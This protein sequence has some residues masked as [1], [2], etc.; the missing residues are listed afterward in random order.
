MQSQTTTTGETMSKST[1]NVHRKIKQLYG[2]LHKAISSNEREEIMRRVIHFPPEY[3]TVF[4]NLIGLVN[5]AF[6]TDENCYKQVK[7]ILLSFQQEVMDDSG[8]LIHFKIKIKSPIKSPSKSPG[9]LKSP[10]KSPGKTK[11]PSKS[12][13]KLMPLCLLPTP[14]THSSQNSVSNLS[15]LKLG[16]FCTAF[17]T[18]SN[19]YER[20]QFIKKYMYASKSNGE[21]FHEFI[22]DISVDMVHLSTTDIDEE[23]SDPQMETQMRNRLI[24]HLRYTNT[25]AAE[26]DERIFILYPFPRIHMTRK[27]KLSVH[28]LGGG[29]GNR[30]FTR[31]R[32]L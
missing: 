23:L 21:S 32:K 15:D 1:W 29:K 19:S 12:P 18:C 17:I 9:K 24:N 6:M 25:K 10:S 20:T 4:K 26:D 28:N 3:E 2:L 14:L 8:E 13:G 31:K 16:I 22:N 30:K 5:N 11:S 27:G 7:D